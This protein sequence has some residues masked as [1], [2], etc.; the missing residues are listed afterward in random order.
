MNSRPYLFRI[1]AGSV[2]VLDQVPASISAMC[3]TF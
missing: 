2:N 3:K 1:L